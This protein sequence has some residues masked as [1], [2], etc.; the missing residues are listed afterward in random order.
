[1][2]SIKN[3]L[4]VLETKASEPPERCGVLDLLPVMDYDEWCEIAA[5][6]QAELIKDLHENTE[7]AT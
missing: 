7:C 6:Q 3:R 5:K 2:P 4:K 1:M